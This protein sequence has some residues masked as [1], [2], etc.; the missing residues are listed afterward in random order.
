M[1][2]F[3][4]CEEITERDAAK[5]VPKG[6]RL[7]RQIVEAWS[8]PKI[9]HCFSKEDGFIKAA[10][11]NR[12]ILKSFALEGINKL[13]RSSN[14]CFSTK[15]DG[16]EETLYFEEPAGTTG[17]TGR[18]RQQH[19]KGP[20]AKVDKRPK[21]HRFLS[22]MRFESVKKWHR[23]DK[24][25]HCLPCF[26]DSEKEAK[27]GKYHIE[28]SCRGTRV[29]DWHSSGGRVKIR[30]YPDHRIR[31]ALKNILGIRSVRAERS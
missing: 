9:K 5:I 11:R 22:K 7:T 8:Q 17:R 13:F 28:F 25:K 15:E 19:P 18:L 29:S 26:D 23:K 4:N 27:N 3:I 20:L 2:I 1:T 30:E 31:S 16:R 10:E 24:N 6:D 14:Y 21:T 12:K